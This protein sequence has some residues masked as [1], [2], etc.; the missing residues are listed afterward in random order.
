MWLRSQLMA[1]RV[2]FVVAKLGR[3]ADPFM[4]HLYAVLAEKERRLVSERTKAVLAAKTA[5]GI[6]LGNP[7]N[8][9]QASELGRRIQTA[10]AYEVVAEL[11]PIIQAIQSTGATTLE[12]ITQALNQRGIR[13]A[14][15]AKWYASLVMNVIEHGK[16]P[17]EAAA[18]LWNGNCRSGRGGA[19]IMRLIARLPVMRSK[20]RAAAKVGGPCFAHKTVYKQVGGAVARGRNG[21]SG[22]TRKTGAS[23]LSAS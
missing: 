14:R 3:D 12:A 23:R 15:G 10:A 2:P 1:Q 22:R 9:A 8:L 4:L 18:V 11:M 17:H 7:R 5:S 20:R 6:K 16:V 21:N 19:I 13:T